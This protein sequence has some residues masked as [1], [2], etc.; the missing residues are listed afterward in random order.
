MLLFTA[1]DDF[2]VVSQAIEGGASGYL[3][4]DMDAEMVGWA[5]KTVV[6]GEY[7]LHP[8][9]AK[10][11]LIAFNQLAGKDNPRMFLQPAVQRPYHLLTARECEVLQLLADGH[12]NRILGETLEISEKTVKNHVSTILQKMNLQDRTQVVVTAIKN[13]WVEL[14]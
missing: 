5:I 11:F 12:S 1:I 14:K 7:Y 9:I 13:G 2:S 4:K 3:L 8:K 10:D 6:K